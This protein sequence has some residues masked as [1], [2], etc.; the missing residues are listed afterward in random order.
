M[1]SKVLIIAGSDSGGGAGIQGDIKAVSA[2]GS[3]AATA[4]TSITVQNTLGVSNVFDLPVNIVS[5]QIEAVLSDIGADVIKTG[6]LSSAEII[7]AVAEKYIKYKKLNPKLKLIL[8]PVMVAK[9]GAKLLQNSALDA[10]KAKLLPI[11]DIVTPNIPEAEILSGIKI[12]NEADMLQAGKKIINDLGVRNVIMKGGHLEVEKNLIQ[13]SNI[14]PQVI[15]LLIKKL[16]NNNFDVIKLTNDKIDTKNTHGTGC[17][18]A[19]SLSAYMAQGFELEQ[20][21]KMA[22][23]Y[24]HKAI[25]NAPDIGGG[26]GPLEHFWMLNNL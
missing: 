24:V 13:T 15:D 11:A 22:N 25:K 3:F 12:V 19:S 23:A 6:M 8:D 21:F 20:A 5:E 16:E 9:G 26:H 17:T 7:E 14:Q 2:C 4:I 10:L 18:F 1:K